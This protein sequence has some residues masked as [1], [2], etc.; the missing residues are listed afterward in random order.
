M[1]KFMKPGKVVMVLAGRYAG[2]K[3]VI[4]KNVDDGTSDRPYIRALVA[5]VDRY[6]RK[7]TTD[8]GKKK[9]TK[10]PAMKPKARWEAKVE[11]DERYKT[12]KNKWFFQKLRLQVVSALL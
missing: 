3:A 6:P 1:G 4:V 10:D 8:M 11:F 2:L 12:G 5:G 9:I 7:V